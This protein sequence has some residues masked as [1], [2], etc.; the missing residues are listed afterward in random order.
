MQS[1]S[2]AV[3]AVLLTQLAAVVAEE[4]EDI[5]LVGLMFQTP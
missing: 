1:S 2:V 4:Q 3:E 5:L